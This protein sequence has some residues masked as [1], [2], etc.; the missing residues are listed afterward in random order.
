LT[1]CSSDSGGSSSPP[2]EQPQKQP[3]TPR[4]FKLGTTDCKVTIKSDDQ[5]TATEWK[6]LCN[7]VVAAIQSEYVRGEMPSL[8]FNQGYFKMEF[9]TAKNTAVKILPSSATYKCEVKVN[10]Q[11]IYLRIDAISTAD[12]QAAVV[13]LNGEST[14]QQE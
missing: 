5:F 6:T 12:L 14:N 4:T 11:T 8:E 1:A 3:D 2:P 7:K 13:A 9:A 10:D